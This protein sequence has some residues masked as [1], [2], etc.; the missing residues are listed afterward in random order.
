MLSGAVMKRL[1]RGGREY[2][3]STLNREDASAPKLSLQVNIPMS[4]Y[5]R[6]VL[7]L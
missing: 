4:V 2:P 7:S 3:V 5:C 6:A 1:Y